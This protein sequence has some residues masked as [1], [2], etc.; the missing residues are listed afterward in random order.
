MNTIRIENSFYTNSFYF[1][2]FYEFI[3]ICEIHEV[4]QY[5]NSVM[6]IGIDIIPQDNSFNELVYK[7]NSCNAQI[8]LILSVSMNSFQSMKSMKSYNI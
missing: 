3:S 8:H 4:I 6:V 1:V 5:M 7:T 2:C